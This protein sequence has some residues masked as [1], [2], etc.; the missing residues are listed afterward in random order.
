MSILA[1]TPFQE[2]ALG[3]QASKK[4]EDYALT[5][6]CGLHQGYN[7]Q[8]RAEV[9]NATRKPHGRAYE[10][11]ASKLADVEAGSGIRNIKDTVKLMH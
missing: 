11:S 3:H 2:A 5:R 4:G 10:S 7:G 9:K 6:I 8:W 1:E